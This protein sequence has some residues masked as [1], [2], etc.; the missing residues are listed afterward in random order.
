M[1]NRLGIDNQAELAREEERLSKLRA[2]E[3]YDCGLLDGREPGT[4]ET[5]RFIH[6]HLFQDVYDFAG[7][8]RDVDIS[9][10]NMR[11]ASSLY[12]TDALSAVE[13]MPQ[14]DFDEVVEKYVEM[15]VAHPFLEGNGRAMR[16]WLDHILSAELG[17]A[18]DW[19]AVDKGAYL[20]AM[21]RS[22]ICDIEIKHVLRPALVDA[23]M[24]R[25]TFMKGLDASYAYEDMH[26]YSVSDLGMPGN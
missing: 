18:V 20:R 10:G 11:F 17:R 24:P 8:V 16:M 15:N 6:R 13:K 22:P 26:A 3:L 1:E 23:D 9:K 5:L 12:L 4:A 2:L 25:E 19:S 7:D 14:G 21:E